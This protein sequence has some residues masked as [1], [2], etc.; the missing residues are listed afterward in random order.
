MAHEL[1]RRG[2]IGRAGAVA[3]V[4][5]TGAIRLAVDG[6]ASPTITSAAAVP[7]YGRHQA[8]ITTPQQRHVVL[9]AFDLPTDALDLLRTLLRDW[10]QTAL[11]LT[12]GVPAAATPDDP[13]KVAADTG[14]TSG[15]S[16]SRLTMTLGVGPSLFDHRFGL[17]G[18][19]P[20]E[21]APLPSF[22]G[23]MLDRRRCDGDVIVQACA[24]DPMVAFHAAR[25]LRREAG[26]RARLRWWQSGFLPGR[27]AGS[28]PRNLLGFKDGI[29]NLDAADAA[30]MDQ[31]VWVGDDMTGRSAWLRGGT[32]LVA[33]RIRF[34]LDDWDSDTV[35]KQEATFGRSKSTGAPLGASTATAVPDFEA[36]HNGALVIPATAHVRLASPEANGGVRLLRR[37][38]SFNDGIDR[39]GGLDAGLLFLAFQRDPQKQFVVLQQRLAAHDAL[40][41]YVQHTGGG[42]YA[43]LPGVAPGESWGAA[44]IDRAARQ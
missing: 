10:T 17:A 30:S 11:S 19:R 5:S 18:A 13:H 4:A 39:S 2:F 29:R 37:G 31:H 42:V 28:A 36:R 35:A 3:A 15:L 6:S 1:S 22:R 21:L 26:R 16:P 33:R 23:D 32:F 12:S 43:M 38:Y 40:N 7:F 8:G 34:Q 41:E 9:A 20:P 27:S 14:E 24:D 25:Q 44:L